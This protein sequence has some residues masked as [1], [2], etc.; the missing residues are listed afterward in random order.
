VNVL[1]SDICHIELPVDEALASG[2]LDQAAKNRKAQVHCRRAQSTAR[3]QFS[4]AVSGALHVALIPSDQIIAGG[5]ASAQKS[6]D[7][8]KPIWRFNEPAEI[9]DRGPVVAGR[10]GVFPVE[11]A[12]QEL[13]KRRGFLDGTIRLERG[14]VLM[15]IS[16][17]PCR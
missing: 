10:V 11:I 15:S 3:F 13:L 2:F 17:S 14:L 12:I 4:F 16:A 1:G 9:V 6:L 5:K 7:R 8:R